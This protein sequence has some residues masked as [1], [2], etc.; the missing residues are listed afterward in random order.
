MALGRL[1]GRTHKSNGPSIVLNIKKDCQMKDLER[2]VLAQ[3]REYG[4]AL[5]ELEDGQK[6]SHWIWY[7][8]PQL[9][10]LGYSER[11]KFYGLADLEE[12]RAYMDHPM[13]GPR[14]LKCVSALMR[15]ED[16]PIEETMSGKVD[17]RKLRSSLTLM[18]AAG[19]GFEVH[20]A[21]NVFF[22]G[23]TCT[24][25]LSELV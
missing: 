14:Y 18:Q 4:T 23:E 8:F 6:K 12:A 21:I 10:T 16:S 25:T 20:K 5:K 19:G 7:I 3:E 13:L 15:H 24:E 17:A 1:I 9:E 11:A 22:D 2:F